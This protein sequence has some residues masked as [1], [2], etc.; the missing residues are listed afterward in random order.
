MSDSRAEDGPQAGRLEG[1][2]TPLIA[3]SLEKS[4]ISKYHTRGGHGFAAED[5]NHFADLIRG[6]VAEVVGGANDLNGADRL[7]NGIKIQSKYFQTAT[8]TVASAFD[9]CSGTYR[10]TGQVLEVPADQYEACVEL[11]RNKIAQGKVPGF[12]KLSD[13]A[14]IVQRGSVTYRQARNIARAGNVD[15]L[16]FDMRTQAVTSS[17]IFAISFVVTFAHSRR[18]GD[19]PKEAARSAVLTALATGS[20]ALIT[21]VIGA[22]LLRTQLAHIGAASIRNG[23]GGVSGT[24]MGRE[25]INRIAAGSLGKGVYGA[26]AVNHVSKLFRSN[27][28]TATVAVGVTTAPDF[29]RAMF[30]RS[31]S[32]RQFGKNL[33]VNVATVATGAIGWIGGATIGATIGTVVPIIGT[34]IGGFI[35]GLAGAAVVG[36]AGAAAAR[37]LADRLIDDDS[38]KISIT[39]DAEFRQM[40]S[41]YM[42]T[43]QEY[44][45]LEKHARRTTTP[46]WLRHA[47]R[48]SA[49][50]SDPEA[51]R[52]YV[53]ETFEA[54]CESL[55]RER[56][57]LLLP[58]PAELEVE[59]WNV[60]E[61]I[62]AEREIA[63]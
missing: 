50:G 54:Q 59:I 55:L 47:F 16:V 51:I 24:A 33:F 8:E 18:R 9:L 39:I 12:T 40:A 11:M 20:T 42:L 10:Y 36:S 60:V 61:A 57:P 14:R 15:S 48:I 7:V 31:I 32:W 43:E 41:E 2:S 58:P 4:Q 17:C 13:A 28:V 38:R 34:L 21:G 29:Y 44:E 52:A 6:K 45:G 62:A 5:A 63:A 56:P 49:K 3:Q 26:A 37:A 23:L 35:G 53:R 22:Q 27:I 19:S 46:R 25:L 1:F 30:A